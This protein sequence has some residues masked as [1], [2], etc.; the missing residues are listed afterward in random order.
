MKSI[1]AIL[2]MMVGISCFAEVF[3]WE[4]ADELN[5][6]YQKTK[7]AAAKAALDKYYAETETAR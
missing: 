5:R 1:F 2:A 4:K 7:S 3:T 6:E